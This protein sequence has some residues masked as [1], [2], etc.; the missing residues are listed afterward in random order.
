MDV[1][2]KRVDRVTLDDDYS[3]N[4]S[5]LRAREYAAFVIV[6]RLLTAYNYD[7]LSTAL[8]LYFYDYTFD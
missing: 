2:K 5:L 1:V 3:F 7:G 6:V 8:Q 4:P